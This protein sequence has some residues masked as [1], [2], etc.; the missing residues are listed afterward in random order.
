MSS[1]I[2]YYSQGE[3]AMSSTLAVSNLRIGNT[4]YDS[5]ESYTADVHSKISAKS[6]SLTAICALA[7]FGFNVGKPLNFKKYEEMGF[8]HPK[9]HN[10]YNITFNE[11]GEPEGDP[12]MIAIYNGIKLKGEIDDPIIVY[13]LNRDGESIILV[14]DG[15]TRASAISYI[16]ADNPDAFTRVPIKV[17]TGT[18]EEAMAEMVRRNMEDR[19]RPLADIEV[20]NAIKR[21]VA[22]GWTKDEISDRLGQDRIKWRAILDNYIKVG[23]ALVPELVEAWS[24]GLLTRNAAFEAAKTTV[25]EQETI[26][27]RINGGEKVTGTQIKKEN[28][29]KREMRPNKT[30]TTLA[31]KFSTES[32]GENASQLA[33]FLAKK[34]LKSKYADTMIE[35][36]NLILA[37]RDNLEAD[38]NPKE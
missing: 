10:Y 11:N 14:L 7:L 12:Q 23:E 15:A 17:F 32:T 19:S 34:R 20:M 26:A 13:P 33:G 18:E 35:I 3:F 1:E 36:R 9:D 25:E 30:L 22:S 37:L 5:L 16:M 38:L 29:E 8:H 27:E 2:I 24:A 31:D 6:T 4:S 28:S 21:F